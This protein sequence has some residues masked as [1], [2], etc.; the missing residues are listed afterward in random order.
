MIIFK[1]VYFDEP[2]EDQYFSEY[3]DAVKNLQ[4]RDYT[5]AITDE[6]QYDVYLKIRNDHFSIARIYSI[7]VK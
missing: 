2:F 1:V 5:K 7:T 3:S 4:L 6:H